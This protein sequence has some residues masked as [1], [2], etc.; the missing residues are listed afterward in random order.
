MII[1][2]DFK[3]R[4][5]GLSLPLL[6]IVISVIQSNINFAKGSLKIVKARG[7]SPLKIN[8]NP[9]TKLIL[10]QVLPSLFQDII[11]TV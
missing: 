8:D 10:P 7:F 2:D 5:F 9:Q 4:S 11:D 3:V 6:L 1:G